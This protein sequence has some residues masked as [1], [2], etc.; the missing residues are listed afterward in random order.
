MKQVGERCLSGRVWAWVWREGSVWATRW[1][2]VGRLG[3]V[4]A[5]RGVLRTNG[6]L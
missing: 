1:R 4:E 6:P 3:H 5:E 2:V